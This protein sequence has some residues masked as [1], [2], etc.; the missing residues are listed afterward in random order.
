[1]NAPPHPL[2]CEMQSMTMGTLRV[3]VGVFAGGTRRGLKMSFPHR[4][5]ERI[6]EHSTWPSYLMKAEKL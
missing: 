4:R 2:T 6:L 3:G 5:K 1:M